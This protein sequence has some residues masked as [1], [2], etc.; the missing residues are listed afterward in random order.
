[1]PKNAVAR[2]ISSVADEKDLKQL[3]TNEPAHEHLRRPA[4]CN[5]TR[6]VLHGEEDDQTRFDPKPDAWAR[7]VKAWDRLK[8]GDTCG[9]EDEGGDDAVDDERR[10]RGRRAFEELVEG[11]LPCGVNAAHVKGELVGVEGGCREVG[12]EALKLCFFDV[13]VGCLRGRH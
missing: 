1:M 2:Q 13:V 11:A 9:R 6:H 5:R 7:R 8:D 3:R 12:E 4:P 10:C